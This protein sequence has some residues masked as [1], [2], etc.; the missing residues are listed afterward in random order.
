VFV[1][2]L[3]LVAGVTQQ[4]GYWRKAEDEV[5]APAAVPAVS[6]AATQHTPDDEFW[7]I[8]PADPQA[9]PANSFER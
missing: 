9:A 4:L 1:F 5:A 2:M 8:R 7:G 3:G 6:V